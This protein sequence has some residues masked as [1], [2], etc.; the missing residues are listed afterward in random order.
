M[1]ADIFIFIDLYILYVKRVIVMM[2]RALVSV[3]LV[4]CMIWI[5]CGS[6][7]G[8]TD[9]A[10]YDEISV[11]GYG[12]QW[13][14][15]YGDDWREGAR[16][17]GPQPIGDADND[18]LNE[19]LIG[20]RD[21]ALRVMEWDGQTYVE[22]AVLHPPGYPFIQSDSGGFA[23]GDLTNNGKNEVAVTWSSCV[24]RFMGWRYWLFA[25]YP[26]LFWKGGG[27]SD[28][29]IG[30]VTGD[31]K[32]ELVVT[33]GGGLI[34][35]VTVLRWNGLFLQKIG[36]YDDSL[37]GNVFM[38][39]IGDVDND[40]YNELVVGIADWPN[41]QGTNRVVVLDW[42]EETKSFDSTVILEGRGFENC[43][44]AIVCKDCD[45]DGQAEIS[46]GYYWPRISV[47]EYVDSEY[48]MSFDVVWE[49]EQELIEGL[50]VGDVDDDGMPEI[51]AGTDVVHILGWDGS[52]YIE[53]AV[54]PTFGCQA[55]VCIGDCD[56][57]GLNEINV[58]SVQGLGPG[59]EYMEWVWKFDWS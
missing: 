15:G 53:E 23:I 21:A 5:S 35:E 38:P 20:G 55:V 34:A 27:S 7:A 59:E 49:G 19:L 13:M 44:F 26:F 10:M 48:V 45:G 9:S 25:S 50:D 16:Y 32:N 8:S 58:A 1:P 30:D 6:Y 39:G 18:G 40:G 33:G 56:N 51:C 36:Q 54:L 4:F 29:M 57:D 52:T 2:S 11:D 46:V 17:Q 12:I 24:Y 43:P 31:G 47:F 3:G 28:C 42:N 41:R 14:Q 22:S 37:D